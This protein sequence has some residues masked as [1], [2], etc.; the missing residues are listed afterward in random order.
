MQN[1]EIYFEN[2]HFFDDIKEE[3]EICFDDDDLNF[4]KDIDE[5]EYYDDKDDSI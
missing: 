2:E 4:E 5:K 3:K 1:E